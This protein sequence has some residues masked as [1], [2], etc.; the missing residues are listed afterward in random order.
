M[1]HTGLQDVERNH[2][3]LLP[4][5]SFH[6]LETENF[7]LIRLVFPDFV[8]YGISEDRRLRTRSYRLA[9]TFLKPLLIVCKNMFTSTNLFSL[10]YRALMEF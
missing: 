8:A 3:Q 10:F 4:V 5:V 9:Q 7:N 1:L 6:I 2:W